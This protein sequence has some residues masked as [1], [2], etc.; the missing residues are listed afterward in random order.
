M[1]LLQ[2]PSRSNPSAV[3]AN[4]ASNASAITVTKLSTQET[5][6]ADWRSV[7]KELDE[8]FVKQSR[9]RMKGVPM[10][11]MPEIFVNNGVQLLEHQVE[12]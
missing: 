6:A 11:E 4:P 7:Q 3:I 10:I 1:Q 12:G 2:K 9:E 5:T 8:L